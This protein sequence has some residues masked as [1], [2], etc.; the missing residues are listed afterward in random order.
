MVRSI[1]A[2]ILSKSPSGKAPALRCSS[3]RWSFSL[4]RVF[5]IDIRVHGTFF[6][7]LLLGALQWGGRHGARGAV[8][9][10]LLTMLLFACV[11]LHEL[12]HSL[13]AKAFGI[14]V[15]EIVLLPIGGVARLEQRPKKAIHE[16][17][18]AVAGPLVNVVVGI[19]LLAVAAVTPSMAH[20]DGEHL[21]R[22]GALEP[23][24]PALVF[25]LMSANFVLAVFNMLPALPMDGGRV[26]RAVLTM[27]LGERRATPIAATIGQILATLLG[28]AGIVTGNFILAFVAVFVFLGAGQERAAVHA[29]TVLSTLRVRDA[30]NKYALFLSPG[31]RVSKVIDYLLTSYQP[32]FAVM[33]G[34]ELVG[35]VTRDDVLRSLATNP[36]DQYVAGMMQRA[37]FRV[38]ASLSLEEVREALAAAGARVAAVYDGPMDIRFLGLVS[39]EDIHEALLITSFVQ[40]QAAARVPSE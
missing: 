40:R 13:V 11:V 16:L 31:D 6:L 15:S 9:G 35:V 23:G 24:A 36:G 30:Y 5:G 20:L 33:H 26:L 3:M 27:L 29:R 22:P 17:L 38:H 1:G 18:I 8:F 12:G 21:S 4:V 14:P 39:L 32:D 7:V 10:V 25:W 34:G 2:S 19:A 28:I 37:V